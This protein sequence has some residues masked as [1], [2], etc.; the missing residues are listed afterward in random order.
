[1]RRLSVFLIAIVIGSA[2]LVVLPGSVGAVAPGSVD[3]IAF[4]SNRDEVLNE[5]YT[6]SADGGPWQRLTTNDDYEKDPA[7]SPDGMQ[8]AYISNA[9]GDADVWVMSSDGGGERN[10]TDDAFRQGEPDWSPDGNR[11]A[12]RQ[13]DP[14]D[15]EWDVWEIDVHTGI[16]TNLTLELQDSEQWDPVYSPDG[17]KIAFVSN[18][19]VRPDVYV[20]NTDGSNLNNLTRSYASWDDEPTWSPDGRQ[21]AFMSSRDRLISDVY[22]IDVDGSNTRR[23]TDIAAVKSKPSWS[24]DG[25]HILFTSYA[26]GNHDLWTVD[27]D[28]SNLTQQT[29]DPGFEQFGAW[30]SVPNT[31]VGLVDPATG[32]WRLRDSKGVVT[33][34]LY[35]VPGDYPLVGDWDCST[36]DTPGV[37][38]QS[39][40]VVYLRN[41][42]AEGVADLAFSFGNPGD[43][44]LAGDFNADGCDTVS[45]YRPS[46]ARF[47]IFNQLGQNG[48]RLGTA[49][50]SFLF[51]D[52]GDMPVVGDWDGDGVD[53]VGLHRVSTGMFY[54][55]NTLSTGIAD[56]AFY[57]G[58]P[59]DRFAAGDW[60]IRDGAATPGVFRPS[61]VSFYFRHSLTQGNADSQFAWSGAEAS[62]LPVAGNF[63]L[64]H[65]R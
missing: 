32:A 54:Y 43:V 31:T 3:R 9:G 17:S 20:M 6:I 57:F 50:F 34:F 37:Y 15:F 53:E 26:A 18:H 45:I 60:G 52:H 22:V 62:W 27:P 63:A 61:D 25:A 16:R 38:R 8:L 24:P 44:P 4:V 29:T 19:D 65:Q 28:G 55:R 12:F 58:D 46:E 39:D 2:G 1:M 40:G 51:G 35:G 48:V 13:E 5:I 23:V 49:D 47:Y 11:I 41:T 64:E 33:Q 7:W 21:I 36:T 56:G 14:A 42:N 59:G 30:E 10:L